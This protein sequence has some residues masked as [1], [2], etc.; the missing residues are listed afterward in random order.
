MILSLSA[1]SNPALLSR[2]AYCEKS[3]IGNHRRLRV[4][5]STL[6]FTKDFNDHRPRYGHVQFQKLDEFRQEQL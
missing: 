3:H 1:L 4:G 5:P 2:P 6:Q